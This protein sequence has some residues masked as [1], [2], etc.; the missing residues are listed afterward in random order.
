MMAKV[1]TPAHHAPAMA[2]Q[3]AAENAMILAIA[4]LRDAL[5]VAR[6]PFAQLHAGLEFAL[7]TILQRRAGGGYCRPDLHAGGRKPLFAARKQRR[8]DQHG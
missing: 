4:L 1:P 7:R 5:H 2:I 6:G 3:Q 8:Y